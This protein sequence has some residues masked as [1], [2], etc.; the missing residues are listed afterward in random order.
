M[1]EL[2]AGVLRSALLETGA[3]FDPRGLML[4]GVRIVGDLDLDF[5]DLRFPLRF[6]GIEMAGH[7]S[8]RSFR[9][10][11]VQVI[12]STIGALTFDR[13][14]IEGLMRIAQCQ[15]PG[16][17]SGTN[18]DVGV[19]KLT[20]STLG[21]QTTVSWSEDDTEAW[22]DTTSHPDH[23]EQ[24][25]VRLNLEM[26]SIGGDAYLNRLTVHG[27]ISAI[28]IRVRGAVIFTGTKIVPCH[29]LA[30]ED[31]DHASICLDNA[32][33]GG[34]LIM[35]QLRAF[36]GLLVRGGH[37]GGQLRL[38]DSEFVIAESESFVVDLSGIEVSNDVRLDRIR[39]GQL[40]I[41]SATMDDLVL[42]GAEFL[43][44]SDSANSVYAINA[45][46]RGRVLF[47][48]S[49]L[50][51]R[52]D[53]R[54]STVGEGVIT[55]DPDEQSLPSE[56]AR[57]D[58]SDSHISGQVTVRA[59]VSKFIVADRVVVT[60][61]FDLETLTKLGAHFV[62]APDMQG[63]QYS[64]IARGAR[65]EH[66]NLGT[67]AQ[68]D[69]A[70][71]LSGSTISRLSVSSLPLVGACRLPSVSLTETWSI[72][73]ISGYVNEGWENAQAWLSKEPSTSSTK[74]GA[75]VHKHG[76]QSWYAVAG[77]FER[78]GRESDA[79]RLKYLATDRLFKQ[80]GAWFSKTVW[81]WITMAAVGHGF[82]SQRSLYGLV[83][84]G[85]LAFSLVLNNPEAFN[86]TDRDAAVGKASNGSIAISDGK[87]D[88]VTIFTGAS[89]PAPVAYPELSAPLY[90]IDVILSPVGSGQAASW[91][92]STDLWLSIALTAIK[93]LSWALLGLFVTSVSGVLS[94]R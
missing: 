29:T 23:I 41:G 25:D 93:L 91:R 48:A 26:A 4:K 1:L 14:N 59:S 84:L 89:D 87:P 77:V 44:D 31:R 37:V 43:D 11:E 46:I 49:I 79:R 27:E 38:E 19:L 69:G 61:T 2:E 39:A 8:M 94:K 18:C 15:I 5:V 58:L 35:Q 57:I 80:R 10:I 92:V 22:E 52:L 73:T 13:A 81:R 85:A 70:F 65:F 7:L 36:G 3:N 86:P 55:V 30:C 20:S 75:P 54:R 88:D 67:G 74:P 28:G 90:A 83:I 62:D 68:I 66:L 72:G 71:D 34:S 21:Q 47:S 6:S 17:V 32:T 45:V 53:L 50:K 51:G 12:K 60:G 42:A 24:V 82:Y 16:G 78:S 9:G 63:T 56:I 33:I 76:V 40:S 64:L